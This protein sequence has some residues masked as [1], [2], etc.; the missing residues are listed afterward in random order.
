MF[1]RSSEKLIQA[2]IPIGEDQTWG[3]AT[4]PRHSFE[5]YMD[6]E[7]MDDDDSFTGPNAAGETLAMEHLKPIIRSLGSPR[8]SADL[9]IDSGVPNAEDDSG[10]NTSA[11]G[12]AGNSM[13]VPASKK[14]RGSGSE[15]GSSHDDKNSK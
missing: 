10:A 7:D 13:V 15:G 14:E 12:E 11:G 3:E 8:G 5:E 2:V 9:T 1:F 4:S 6:N